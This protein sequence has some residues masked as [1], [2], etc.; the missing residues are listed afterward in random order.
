MISNGLHEILTYTLISP[1]LDEKG[2][3]LNNDES[4]KIMN[5]MTVEH[6]LVRRGLLPSV[7]EVLNYNLSHQNKDIALFEVSDVQTASQNYKEL[8]I[9][10]NGEKGIRGSLVK[11]PYDFYDIYGYFESICAILGIDSKRYKVERLINDAHFHPGRS[12]AIYFG[13]ECVGVIGELHPNVSKDYGRTYV[14]DI[15]LSK[16]YDLRCPATKMQQISRFP[17]VER[18]YA[19]IVK[20]EI[21]A[22]ELIRIVKKEAHGIVSDVSIFDVYQGEFLPDGMKS[23]AIKIRYSSLEKTL[24]DTDINPVESGILSALNRNLG[25]YLRS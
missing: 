18:D 7:L 20:K 3:F 1:T 10:L 15:N 8:T 19:F 21:T 13:K 6:S 12:V 22:A 9:V 16:F 17:A 2:F 23:I 14:L 5:P 11:Q 24:K 4:I 25:A